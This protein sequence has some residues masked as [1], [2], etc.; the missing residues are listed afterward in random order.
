MARL[1]RDLVRQASTARDSGLLGGEDETFQGASNSDRYCRRDRGRRHGRVCV[2][3][4]RGGNHS[5]RRHQLVHAAAGTH[6]SL[7]ARGN[8]GDRRVQ[9]RGRR[10]R[11]RARV[12]FARR[13]GETGRGGQGGRAAL[14]P[15]RGGSDLG[16]AVQPCRAGTDRLRQADPAIVHRSRAVGRRPGLG[17][18]Q[19]LHL[20]A[21]PVD[22]HAGGDA[23]RRGSEGRGRQALGNHRA[24]L[25]VRQGCCRGVSN[26]C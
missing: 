8:S 19:P 14:R 2:R 6:G 10:A 12:H 5:H 9:Q 17:S 26:G 24:Q 15:R 1:S 18:G 11:A 13:S 22:L 25:R 16:L 7:P 4:G 21:A 3:V 23:R 20:P